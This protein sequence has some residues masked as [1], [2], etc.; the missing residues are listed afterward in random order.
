MPEPWLS[1]TLHPSQPRSTGLFFHVYLGL[2]RTVLQI[3]GLLG[4]RFSSGGALKQ[5]R[6]SA[7]LSP[8][9]NPFN[10]FQVGPGASLMIDLGP[11][12]PLLLGDVYT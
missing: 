2:L 8:S 10:C 5:S 11:H 12:G 9:A 6:L 3:Q 1:P 4:F 7:V